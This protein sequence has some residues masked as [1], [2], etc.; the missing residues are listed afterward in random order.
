MLLG[1]TCYYPTLDFLRSESRKAASGVELLQLLS[2]QG[3]EEAG[4]RR[5]AAD[6]V[7]ER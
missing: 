3:F 2:L 6:G 1:S 4:V 5:T 7:F